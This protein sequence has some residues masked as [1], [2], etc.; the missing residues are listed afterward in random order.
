MDNKTLVWII[1]VPM[2]CASRIEVEEEQRSQPTDEWL[3]SAMHLMDCSSKHL[4]GIARPVFQGEIG[5]WQQIESCGNGSGLED[6]SG[7][8]MSKERDS[9]HFS[10]R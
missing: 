9:T 4:K 10:T 5:D 3:K 1:A 2:G 8:A 7:P 6:Y